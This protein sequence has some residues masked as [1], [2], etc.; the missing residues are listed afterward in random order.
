MTD[1]TEQGSFSQGRFGNG[2]GMHLD[3]GQKPDFADGKKPNFGEGEMPEPPQ[4]EFGNQNGE[5]PELPAG[6]A[7]VVS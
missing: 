5:M 2:G 1:D 7:P 3:G 4:G 6:T